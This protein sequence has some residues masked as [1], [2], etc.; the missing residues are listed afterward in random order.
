MAAVGVEGHLGDVL[1][2]DGLL[3][4]GVLCLQRQSFGMDL[5]LLAGSADGQ[6]GVDGDAA[7]DFQNDASL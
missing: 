7:A 2:V 3:E 1:L 4:G 6:G 5:D